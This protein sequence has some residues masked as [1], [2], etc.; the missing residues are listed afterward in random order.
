MNDHVQDNRP[1]LIWI[2]DDIIRKMGAELGVYAIST[3]CA[4]VS[5]ANEAGQCF[6]GIKTIA[7]MIGSSE[8][9]VKT[10]I[11]ILSDHNLISVT[12]RYKNNSKQRE[13]NLYSLLPIGVG[14]NTT[15]GGALDD[16]EV[17]LMMIKR[18]Y[19]EVFA[20]YP[21]QFVQ[22]KLIGLVSE[23]TGSWVLDALNEAGIHNARSLAYVQSVLQNWKQ[24]GKKDT[25][26]RKQAHGT[27]VEDWIPT[28]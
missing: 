10:A 11:K 22:D 25:N 14:Q 8:T 1:R 23:Y 28:P 2:Y 21:T 26:G 5:M 17:V 24:N 6:P 3:Y 7:S 19:N 27:S 9:S 12:A 16:Q 18:K 15:Q 13:S 20:L 4:I